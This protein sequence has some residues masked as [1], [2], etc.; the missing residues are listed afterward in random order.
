MQE[1]SV[2]MEN[3]VPSLFGHS[4]SRIQDL[5]NDGANKNRFTKIFESK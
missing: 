5:E 1:I 3:V 4:Q 2:V